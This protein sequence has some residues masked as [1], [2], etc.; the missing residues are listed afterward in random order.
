MLSTIKRAKNHLLYVIFSNIIFGFIY[1][2]VFSQLVKHSLLAA[3][4]GCLA[5]IFIGL[6]LDKL[7]L[8]EIISEKTIVQI[9]NLSA[10]DQ[11]KNHRLI[12][13]LLNSF[14][15]FKTILF[16]FYFFILIAS[17]VINIA[18]SLANENISRFITANS[19]GMVLL[20]A[21]DRIVGQFSK[22]REM[23]VEKSELFEVAMEEINK[24]VH[25]A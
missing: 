18:P 22:D 4:L 20:L 21:F 19:Y 25:D 17:Q 7:I 13:T 9:K 12:Q 3:Y 11:E 14:V 23:I 24:K 6:Y 8:R 15:S 16:V 5:L 1:Y 2:L 10:T